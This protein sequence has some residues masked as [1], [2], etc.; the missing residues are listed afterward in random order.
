MSY[1]LSFTSLSL[2]AILSGLVL[3]KLTALTAFTA[4]G[5]SYLLTILFYYV[6][7]QSWYYP[8]YVSPLRRIPTPPCFPLW[9]H[10]PTIFTNETGVPLRKWHQEYG[11]VVRYFYLLGSER[12]SVVDQESIKQVTIKN[13]YNYPKPLSVKYW[14][15]RILGRDGILLAEGGVHVQQRKVLAPGFSTQSIKTLYPIFWR[16]ALL[17]SEIWRQKIV[18]DNKDHKYIEVL[19]GLNRTTLDIIGQAG[20]GTEI[21]SLRRPDAPLPVAYKALFTF[22][23]AARVYHAL[24]SK[25]TWANYL[26]FKMNHDMVKSRK[27]ICDAATDIINRKLFEV[28]SKDKDIIALTIRGFNVPGAEQL[29]FETM[30]DQ[31]MTF[32]GAGHDT[33]ATGAAWT[34]HLLAKHPAIQQRLRAEI[35]QHMPSLFDPGSREDDAKLANVDVDQLPYLEN[36]CRESLRYIPP[37][38]FTVRQSVSE[39]RLGGYI[40]PPHTYVYVH[41]NTINQLPQYWG[42]TAAEFDPDRWDHLPDTY[43]PEAFMTFLQGPRGCIGRKFAETEMKT[44]LCSLLSMY[45]FE[46]DTT[47]DDP[48]KWKMWRIVLRPKDGIR[49][50]VSQLV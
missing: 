47:F 11:N 29:S 15:G 35:K 9:G 37:I 43:C 25:T 13:P 20:F 14:M 5:G 34:L 18:K 33:T 24:N 17:L 26:P 7:Y 3:H 42:S 50:K 31:I 12:L 4:F 41:A 39:D 2:S 16:K 48:E 1:Q 44:L 8:F 6:L 32:L 46:P 38:P 45:V 49:L 23:L 22:S 21:D 28:D 30:R 19:E 10:C 40:I 27:V 36:V